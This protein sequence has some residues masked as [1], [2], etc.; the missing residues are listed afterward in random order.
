MIRNKEKEVD[1]RFLIKY[2]T[3]N[4][5]TYQNPLKIYKKN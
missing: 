4:H 5:W 2:L 1:E 3:K